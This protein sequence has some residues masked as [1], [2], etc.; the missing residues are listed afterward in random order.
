[1]K[2]VPH[3]TMHHTSAASLLDLS[4]S[5][6]ATGRTYPRRALAE[7]PL[8]LS[9]VRYD[10]PQQ[11]DCAVHT[12]LM[13]GGILAGD[14]QALQ[15]ML[16]EQSRA[17]VVMAAA[18]QVLSM[19]VG[20]AE[21]HIDI[22]LHAHSCLEWIAQPTIL[23]AGAAF[24]QTSTI[25]MAQSARLAWLDILVPG[26]LARGEA[27]RYRSYRNRLEIYDDR[28]NL[29]VTEHSVLEPQLRP[30]ATPGVLGNTPVVGSLYLLGN[31]EGATHLAQQIAHQEARYLGVS[32]LPNQAGILIRALG[33]SGSAVR[34]RLITLLP[35]WHG[36]H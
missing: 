12:L 25:I 27:H 22:R 32:V 31:Q 36:T 4:F 15:I 30:T 26:R 8:Q 3:T 10:V 19:P 18:T 17:R 35:I 24:S 14:R 11:A 20:H 16:D 1:L 5:R 28:H 21:Q 33:T 13:L 6:D 34:E 9:R 2:S 23:F 7:P 29:L